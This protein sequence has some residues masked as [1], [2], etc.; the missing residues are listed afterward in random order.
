MAWSKPQP[1]RRGIRQRNENSA[2][3]PILDW[4][5]RYNSTTLTNDGVAP[6]SSTDH[7]IPQSLAYAMLAGLPP[8]I[9]LYARFLPLIA[10][11]IFGNQPD[12]GGR[13]GCVVSRG[14]DPDRASAIAAPGSAG[15]YRRRIGL[16]LLL[17]LFLC[18][19]GNSS[20]VFWPICFP[21]RCV[22]IHH[23]Q[24]HHH[25]N[26]PVEAIFGI[27][28][29]VA[30]CHARTGSSICRDDRGPT[31]LPTADH[32]RFATACLFW[33]PQGSETIADALRY[34]RAAGGTGG[35]GWT[36]R[37][38][39]PFRTIRRSSCLEAEGVKRGWRYRSA[40]PPFSVFR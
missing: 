10:Y 8:E 9:G 38:P 2:I 29:V 4:G 24:R 31:M 7:A 21:I 15:I 40:V 1:H 13:T 20:S 26:Q 14:D 17:G 11:A 19:L 28:V 25:R 27:K 5:S 12:I 33:R 35:Q 36:D 23:R 37:R 34:S 6:S 16:A 39:L 30:A 22:G 32:R 18:F 3:L